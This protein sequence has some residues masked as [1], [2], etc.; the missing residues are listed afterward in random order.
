M[1]ATSHVII[2]GAVGIAT[3]LITQNPVIALSAG[4]VSHLICDLIPHADH[5]KAPRDQ[6]NELVWTKSVWIFA[7]S[8]SIIAFLLTLAIWYF[9]FDLNLASVYAWGAF[10]G[11]LPDFIDNVPFWKQKLRS[12]FPIKQFHRLH[13][14]IHDVWMI[15][16][17]QLEYSMLGIVTQ[18]I[19]VLPALWFI[20]K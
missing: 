9:K 13:E 11:Y 17:P 14:W 7:Y 18:L 12:H 15:P 19:T 8:D 1:I 2:G 5:P 3:G 6:N 20:L 10:G 16:F 4:I